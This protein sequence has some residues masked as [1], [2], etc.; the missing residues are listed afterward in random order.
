MKIFLIF[1]LFSFIATTLASCPSSSLP[2]QIQVNSDGSLRYSG[3]NLKWGEGV[4]TYRMGFEVSSASVARILLSGTSF[5]TAY[6]ENIDTD[7]SFELDLTYTGIVSTAVEFPSGKY[8]LVLNGGGGDC[9]AYRLDFGIEKV[10]TLRDKL[11]CPSTLPSNHL[12]KTSFAFRK[13]D[14]S[15]SGEYQLTV[16]EWV[17]HRIPS[18]DETYYRYNVEARSLGT[19]D[20]KATLEYNFVASGLQITNG[21][22]SPAS[23]GWISSANANSK[24]NYK[25]SSQQRIVNQV[26]SLDIGTPDIALG[27]D[28][29]C[30]G[31]TLNLS[32]QTTRTTG[33]KIL[34]VYP[35]GRSFQPPPASMS[36]IF[37]FSKP[38]K[39]P[40]RATLQR[41]II[42]SKAIYL[43]YGDNR[44][45][46][47]NSVSLND[48]RDIVTVTFNNLSAGD[49]DIQE[50]KLKVVPS[51]FKDNNGN[52]Y[53]FDTS[54]IN[55]VYRI[56][57]GSSPTS[58]A[59]FDD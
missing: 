14:F 50:Y 41:T 58:G 45:V 29:S 30:Y 47:P 1:F 48:N 46:V 27:L 52:S 55:T 16:E 43:E 7:E 40:S 10:S 32:A 12:P 44:K 42:D 49:E 22:Y 54:S 59:C 24:Y 9:F 34:W 21:D 11:S 38:F 8:N 17:D 26:G 18:N 56:C 19:T 3:S 57:A 15:F 13:S 53:S 31:L 2:T 37:G 36:L 25:T 4:E 5:T 39:T 33:R 35:E 51:T 6:V 28:D 23:T 20:V